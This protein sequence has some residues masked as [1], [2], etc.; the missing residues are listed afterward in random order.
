M[1]TAMI[2]CFTATFTTNQNGL[3][4]GTRLTFDLFRSLESRVQPRQ[5]NY[6][7]ITGLFNHWFRTIDCYTY[8]NG[9]W[10]SCHPHFQIYNLPARLITEWETV[11]RVYSHRYNLRIVRDPTTVIYRRF[12]CAL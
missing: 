11:E 2:L 4:T 6:P 10:L 8:S 5:R 1:L 7:R 9:M 3:Y 12:R